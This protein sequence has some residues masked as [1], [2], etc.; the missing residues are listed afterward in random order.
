MF[1]KEEVFKVIIK[2]VLYAVTALA[3]Q[4]GYSSF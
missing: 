2:A 3:A 4:L 1:K